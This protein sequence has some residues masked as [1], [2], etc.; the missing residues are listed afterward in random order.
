ML[1]QQRRRQHLKKTSQM[2]TK[3]H[4]SRLNKC[5]FVL[6][7]LHVNIQAICLTYRTL[8]YPDEWS[9]FLKIE[10]VTDNAGQT[11]DDAFFY[12]PNDYMVVTLKEEC[13]AGHTYRMSISEFSGE[14]GDDLDGLYRSE[15]V[16]DFGRKK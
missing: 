15:Y 9:D 10:D 5:F 13:V 12:Q 14:L 6:I 3:K 7:Y 8:I 4:I 16:D 2:I 1:A 11:I